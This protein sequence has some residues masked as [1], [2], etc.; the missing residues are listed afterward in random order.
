MKRIFLLIIFL[1]I[2]LAGCVNQGTQIGPKHDNMIIRIQNNSN[3]DFKG[4]ELHIMNSTQGGLN[5]D[6][7]PIKK[8]ESMWF[9]Y[10]EDDFPLQGEAQMLVK[11]ITDNG[12]NSN[13]QLVPV[14]QHD[15]TIE[16]SRNKEIVFEIIGDSIDEAEL[17]K[18]N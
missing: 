5:A 17:V 18:A 7:S 14:I 15:T 1:I 11:L 10:L 9:E 12:T 8:G 16:I 6:G 13:H 4:I 3:F 2:P